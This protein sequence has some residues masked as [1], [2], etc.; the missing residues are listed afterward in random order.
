MKGLVLFLNWRC[1]GA[2]QLSVLFVSGN[3]QNGCGGCAPRWSFCVP[4]TKVRYCQSLSEEEKKELQ[5]FSAQRKK[6]ALG[7]GTIKLLSR[8][9]MHAVCEQVALSRMN[10]PWWWCGW[11][12]WGCEGDR[13]STCVGPK[14]IQKLSQ[15]KAALYQMRINVYK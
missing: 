6:E 15:R 12:S 10:G 2:G 3:A 4:S 7:R 13:A 9:V 1:P 8:A 5:V 11:V 14:G